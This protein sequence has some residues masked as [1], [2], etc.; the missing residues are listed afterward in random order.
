MAIVGV[1]VTI[2]SLADRSQW[3]STFW[4]LIVPVIPGVAFL[5]WYFRR[6]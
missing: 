4:F 3:D 2:G 1:F 5:A 6:R